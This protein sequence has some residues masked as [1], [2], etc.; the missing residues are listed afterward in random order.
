GEFAPQLTSKQSATDGVPSQPRRF[1]SV[2]WD[3][4]SPGTSDGDI[5][6]GLYDAVCGPGVPYC[7]GDGS[8]TACPCNNPGGSGQ[9]CRNSGG[10]GARLAGLGTNDVSSA[11]LQLRATN[12]RPGQ[13]GLFFQGNTAL[14]LGNGF[15]FG[16]GLRCC[17][18]G[19][20]RLQV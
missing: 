1:M 9:G 14:N 20:I 3:H 2:W 5:E 18:T 19:V 6:G 11:N 12:A 16:D 17:G 4:D 13:P 7:F 15:V 10:S 8:S